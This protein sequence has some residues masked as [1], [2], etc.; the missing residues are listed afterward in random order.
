MNPSCAQRKPRDLIT[1]HPTI[2]LEVLR[3]RA[4]IRFLNREPH[5]MYGHYAVYLCLSAHTAEEYMDQL[6]RV[7]LGLPCRPAHRLHVCMLTTTLCV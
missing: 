6:G 2:P 5:R 7:S 4:N 1:E 3:R